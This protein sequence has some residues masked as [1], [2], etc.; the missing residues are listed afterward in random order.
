MDSKPEMKMKIWLEL[1]G[2][3]AFG[4]GSALLL[5]EIEKNGSLAGAAKELK[6]SYRAAWGRL[7]KVQTSL[8]CPLVEKQGGNKGG[9]SLTEFGRRILE[10]YE[11]CMAQAE[12]NV[13]ESFSKLTACVTERDVQKG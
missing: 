10:T 9:Y 5:R 7:R 1:E 11:D 4:L 12:R 8:G 6:M 3:M 13:A 2:E